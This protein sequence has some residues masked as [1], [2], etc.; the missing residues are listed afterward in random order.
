MGDH[1]VAAVS[2]ADALHQFSRALLDDIDALDRMLRDGRLEHGVTRIGLE[3]EFFL[4]DE[5]GR[6]APIGPE[7]LATLNDPSFTTEIGRF[8]LELNVDPLDLGAGAL[9]SLEHGVRSALTKARAAA[10]QHQARVM[11]TG[12]LPSITLADLSLDNLTP[13][14]RYHALNARMVALAGG[15]MRTVVQGDELLQVE[16]DSVMLEACN[17]SI[18]VHLQVAPERLATVYNIAQLVA[19]PV[20]AAAVNSPL[21]L[22]RRLW[23][24]SR[25]PTFEQA[26]DSRPSADRARGSWQ[27]VHFGDDWVHDSVLE[28]YRDQ[29]ARHQVLL[30]GDTGESSL[31]VLDRGEVPKLRALSLHNGSL[32]RWNRLCYGVS[33]GQP[34]LRIEHR[35]L[36]SGPTILDE[37]ANVA[38]F[39]GLVLGIEQEIGDVRAQFEFAD[40][41]ANF[42]AAAHH[43]LEAELCWER[44]RR[45]PARQLITHTLLPLAERG[46]HAAGVSAPEIGRTLDVIAARA[47][48]GRTGARWQRDAWDALRGIRNPIARAQTLTRAMHD[49]QWAVEP[50]TAWTAVSDAE[51]ASWPKHVRRVQEIMSTDLFTAHPDDLLD[52]ATRVMRW[53]HVRHVPV[54]DDAGAL[55]GLLSHRTLLAARDLPPGTSRAVRDVM[56]TEVHTVAPTTRCLDALALLR[57]RA[58]GCLPVVHDG[59]LVGMVSERDFLPFAE[60]WLARPAVAS[61]DGSSADGDPIATD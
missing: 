51:Q 56:A 28:V 60:Q 46:L 54:Q 21:L 52:V 27:R 4:I 17:T 41:R 22:Q 26:V 39:V 37:V 19:G 5:D 6:P 20:L 35:P 50:V 43:G 13:S 42:H 14:D 36:P 16:L 57:E 49:R 44:G 45:E 1:H 31:A 24:E 61:D 40:V 11:L 15:R 59:R 38:F 29:I 33:Q 30:V 12:V 34:H 23:H 55:V 58:I 3:Q 8:N 25:I 2:D 47:A 10:S 7:V 53:K 32:Y 9:T 48:S 18:Q